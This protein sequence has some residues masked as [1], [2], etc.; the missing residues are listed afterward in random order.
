MF[1]MFR[2]S[3]GSS[4]RN[5]LARGLVLGN[6]RGGSIRD[7]IGSPTGCRRLYGLTVT[8]SS[9]IVR[10]DRG[11]GRGIVGFTHRSN[12]PILSCRPTSAC[13]STFGRFC[14]GM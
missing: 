5:G 2:S 14:S 12:I 1:S 6:V 10:G 13:M 7:V 3:F 4:Y 8:C 9:N 11:I